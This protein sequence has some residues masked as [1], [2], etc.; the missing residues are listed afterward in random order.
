MTKTFKILLTL[1]I[2]IGVSF[3]G[4]YF[5]NRYPEYYIN[6]TMDPRRDLGYSLY[7]FKNSFYET[8]LLITLVGSIFIIGI[9]LAL[10]KSNK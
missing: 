6:A 5:I 7:G 2:C 1:W 8:S 4:F 3:S 10:K 9:G